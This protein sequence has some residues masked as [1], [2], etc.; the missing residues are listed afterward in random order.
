MVAVKNTW[1]MEISPPVDVD[2]HDDVGTI[3][4]LT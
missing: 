1:W 3:L 4:S 2:V